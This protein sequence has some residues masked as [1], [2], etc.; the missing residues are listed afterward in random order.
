M[1]AF[2]LSSSMISLLVKAL[3]CAEIGS[4]F[5]MSKVA[6]LPWA[7]AAAASKFHRW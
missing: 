2:H 5:G 3:V 4:G 6:S 1:R 7:M